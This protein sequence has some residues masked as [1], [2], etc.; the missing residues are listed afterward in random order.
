MS[1]NLTQERNG[2]RQSGV[3]ETAN[4]DADDPILLDDNNF[5]HPL[6]DEEDEDDEGSTSD[7]NTSN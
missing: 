2:G 7:N 1:P 4:V 3:D 5:L 6:T